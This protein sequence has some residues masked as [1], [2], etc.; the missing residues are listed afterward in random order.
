MKQMNK[1]GQ[2]GDMKGILLT[3]AV[4]AVLLPIIQDFIGSVS[5]LSATEQTALNAVTTFVVLG[6]LF[7]AFKLIR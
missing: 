5:N 2:A 4:A 3:V 7:T 6:V 1:K